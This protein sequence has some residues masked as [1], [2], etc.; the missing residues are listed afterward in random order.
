MFKRIAAMTLICL[1]AG[2]LPAPAA[3]AAPRCFPE[4]APAISAC[5]DGPIADFWANGGGLP[6]F[7][8]PTGAQQD[9]QIEGRVLQAQ[10][11]ERSRLELHPENA[12]PYDVVLGRLGAE[13]LARQGRDWHAFPQA[14]PSAPHFFGE[15]GHAI[16]PQFWHYWASHGLELDGQ[17]GTSFQESL[18]LFGLPLSEAQN[19]IN[20]A[21]G[22]PY[23]TQW[24]ERARFEL[25]PEN[26]GTPSE[27]LLGLLGRE[28]DA[29]AALPVARQFIPGD[30]IQAAGR[31]LIYKGRPIQIKGV[32]YY[33]QWRPWG[34]MW[35]GW[36]GPQVE[37]ELRAAR[38]QLGVNT[39]RFMVSYNF[40]SEKNGD[41]VVTPKMIG[42]L[43]E[44]IQIAG[45]L[46]LR[47]IMTLFD[48]YE[49]F[50]DSGTS[51][52][53][54]NLDYLRALLPN[55]AD[56]DRILAWDLH[57]EP[58][59]YGI[60]KAGD[61]QKVLRWLGRIADE[62]HALAPRHLVTVG[63]GRA[64]NLWL[65]GPDGRRVVD[66]SDLVS[67]HTYDAGTVAQELDQLRAQ[68]TKPIIVEEFGWP[69][70][71]GCMENYSETTQVRLYQA[72]LDAAKDRTSGV[73]AWTLRDYD[74][75]P[76]DRWDPFEDNF[77]LIRPDG[78]LKPAAQLMQAINVPPLPSTMVTNKP[79]TTLT[80]HLPDGD[81]A[82]LLIRESGHYV[83]AMFR[84]AWEN[85][86]GRASFGL[87]LS[88]AFVRKSDRV[89]MQYFENAVL[90][91]YP[92]DKSQLRGLSD[93]DQAM[94]VIQPTDL[95]AASATGRSLPPPQPPQGG[96]LD[97][98]NSINGHWRLGGPISAELTETIDGV[99][100]RVQYFQK[101]R[102]E[103][104]PAT[105]TVRV[106]NLGQQALDVQ[107]VKAR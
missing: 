101:G 56:D 30:F 79:L 32:N 91:F 33:P 13:L 107:C 55:F 63:M 52:E 99:P 71:P 64:S 67:M 92:R 22:K 17:P 35:K 46:N 7:G 21:D 9:R 4:A 103:L 31:Q 41:G 60:W 43:N 25:H 10:P 40:F 24:F 11:F 74:A 50:P 54:K 16:A 20:P 28:L 97:F 6:V 12:A 81:S 80:P 76:T 58:D 44:A 70:G 48:F 37:R 49:S 105:K 89:V 68:T 69:T 100:T 42:R 75:G 86:G 5:I 83:K 66:Y 51:N 90:E 26:A 14:D 38:D 82:P 27:V 87:P 102:L 3:H 1:S 29:G 77:G 88:E 95:G 65:P 57:N 62:V 18:A 15:T 106:G 59:H 8:Y 61:T 72:V 2:A 96:F 39:V 98:Y 23:L 85:L 84:K 78:S 94:L 45:S 19:E 34:A 104:N 93:A 36:D 47:V 53:A 73:V